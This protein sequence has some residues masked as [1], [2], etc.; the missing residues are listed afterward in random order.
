MSEAGRVSPRKWQYRIA[1]LRDDV[2]DRLVQQDRLFVA[3]VTS[4]DSG[5]KYWVQINFPK[6]GPPQSICQCQQGFFQWYPGMYGMGPCCKHAEN[7]IF[8]L[9]EKDMV[10][11]VPQ[12]GKRS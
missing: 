10:K 8:F 5:K 2:K 7:L 12:R 3:E 1:D 11:E 4:G 6:I 9:K